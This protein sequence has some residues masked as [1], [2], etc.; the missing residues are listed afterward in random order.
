MY[1]HGVFF[2]QRAAL[3]RLT[4]DASRDRRVA[5]LPRRGALGETSD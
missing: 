2:I 5:E 3:D 1:G 4:F